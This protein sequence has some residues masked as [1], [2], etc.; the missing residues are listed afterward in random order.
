MSA[1]SDSSH[2]M[3]FRSSVASKKSEIRGTCICTI[4][5]EAPQSRELE[6]CTDVMRI[7]VCE[8]KKRIVMLLVGE[9]EN[10]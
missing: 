10:K 7:R 1:Y 2:V 4:D 3:K 9:L 5:R 6:T 8:M